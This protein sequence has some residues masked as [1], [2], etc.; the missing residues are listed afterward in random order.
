MIFF[1]LSTVSARHHRHHLASIEVTSPAF[2]AGGELPG[3]FCALADFLNR[4]KIE[5]KTRGVSLPINVANVPATSTLA[6]LAVANVSATPH[7]TEWLYVNVNVEANTNVF[8]ENYNF[9][10]YGKEATPIQTDFQKKNGI[11]A[12]Y[13][14]PINRNSYANM[15]LSDFSNYEVQFYL[16]A[17]KVTDSDFA[18]ALKSC[19]EKRAALT[20]KSKYASIMAA[21]LVT[22]S[23]F[24][25]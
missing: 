8:K 3:K 16:P 9:T 24:L 4:D 5:L 15:L 22:L 19:G 7:E 11:T 18:T 25:F 13:S 20:F 21:A 1:W 14:G 10:D 23:V 2:A 17:T 12:G 6:C